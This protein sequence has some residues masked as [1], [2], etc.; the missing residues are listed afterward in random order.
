MSPEERDITALDDPKIIESRVVETYNR[1]DEF[2]EENRVKL[3]KVLE[4]YWETQGKWK[5]KNCS[6][7]QWVKVQKVKSILGE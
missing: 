7:K 2:S 1:I 6:K 3:A 4:V 5:K